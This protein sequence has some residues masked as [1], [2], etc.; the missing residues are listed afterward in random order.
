MFPASYL[1]SY[2]MPHTDE[3]IR[4][5]DDITAL[6]RSRMPGVVGVA[7]DLGQ[8]SE[9]ERHQLHQQIELAKALRPMQGNA[10]THVLTPTIWARRLG[11]CA[12]SHTG[13]G[14]ESRF[15]LFT[16]CCRTHDGLASRHPA[17]GQLRASFVRSWPDG[18]GEWA[19]LGCRW[20][21]DSR[22]AGVGVA[23]VCACTAEAR[24]DTLIRAVEASKLGTCDL[25]FEF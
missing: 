1:F 21:P 18:A 8:L 25:P 13:V 19:R 15:C 22:G 17:G 12:T 6:V 11:G 24:F 16:W 4:G 23:G 2:V 3:P 5:A 20:F 7:A 14:G 9:G 10:V